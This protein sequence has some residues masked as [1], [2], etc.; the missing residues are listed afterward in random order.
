MTKI[1]RNLL[2]GLSCLLVLC[3]LVFCLAGCTQTDSKKNNENKKYDVTIKVTNNY[4]SEWIFT[5]DIKELSYEFA[6]TGEDMK[7]YVDS[8]NLPDHPKWGNEWFTNT[9]VGANVFSKT[10]IYTDLDGKPVADK[11]PINEKGSYSIC[12][13]ADSTSDLWNYRYIFLNVTVI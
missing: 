7:F 11:R 4:G 10:M 2:Y 12:F 1:K 6:Y 5:P 9:G 13:E 8:Y 3:M